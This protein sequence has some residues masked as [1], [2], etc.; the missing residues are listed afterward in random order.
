MTRSQ[1]F[2][3]MIFVPGYKTDYLEKARGF[4]ADAL[5]LDLEDSVPDPFKEDARENIRNYLIED[6]FPQATYVRVNPSDSDMFEA[7]LNFVLHSNLSGVMLPKVVDAEHVRLVDRLLS[8]HELRLGLENGH[9]GIVPLIE[10]GIAIIHAHEIACASGRIKA[11]AFGGEDYLTD[12][13]GL[14]K[15]HGRSLIVPRSLVV[16]AARAAGVDVVDT[17]YLNIRDSEGFREEAELAR[18]LGFSGMLIVHPEQ[19]SIANGVFSPSAEEV[20]EAQAIIDAIETSKQRGLQVTLVDG[21]LVGPPMLK[22]AHNVLDKLRRIP[23]TVVRD[24]EDS[25]KK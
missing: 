20:T 22:R 14:H 17:P 8:A 11:L 1:S 24:E 10:S 7:D 25:S 5:I 9:F 6:A 19:L 13:D 3:T 23:S 15:Q 18:E 4:D 21:D 16:I 12:L 2:R